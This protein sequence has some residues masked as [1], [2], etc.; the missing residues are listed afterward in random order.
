MSP[1]VPDWGP[2]ALRAARRRGITKKQMEEAWLYGIEEK[3]TDNCHRI[4]GKDVTLIMD[5]SW[6]FVVTVYH[7]QH[8]DR[9]KAVKAAIRQENGEVVM[10]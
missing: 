9:F 1:Y 10:R 3:G 2:H 5:R 4:I 6:Y 7:N 8:K